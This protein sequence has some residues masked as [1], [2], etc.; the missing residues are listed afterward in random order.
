MGC[1]ADICIM[2]L[3]IFAATEREWQPLRTKLEEQGWEKMA[4]P[5]KFICTGPGLTNA[6]FT[7]TRSIIEW[8]PSMAIQIGIA[9]SYAET[10]PTGTAVAIESECLG[11]TGV[12]ENGHFRDLFDL[13]L[14][15]ADQP[16]FE[17][18]VLPNPYISEWS[19][20]RIPLVKGVSVNEIT[21]R[22]SDI[23]RQNQKYQ[24]VSESMEGA[25]FHYAALSLGVPFL[26][27]RGLSNFI[28][29]R[30]K[31]KWE[32]EKAL[33]VVSEAAI[34]FLSDNI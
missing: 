9:G 22:K 18:S 15:N 21:T 4:M 6:T 34:R 27:L 33:E 2:S 32:I 7:I 19:L 10:Y 8:K 13:G 23:E 3:L 12:W 11:D 26:Q 17:N 14:L 31:K 30:D 5:P 16:P 28:G 25:A 29:E 1:N 24:A 20:P